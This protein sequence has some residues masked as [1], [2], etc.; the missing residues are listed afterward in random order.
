MRKVGLASIRTLTAG[1][2]A[3]ARALAVLLLAFAFLLP[4]VGHLDLCL[5]DGDQ[6]GFLC[7]QPPA[8]DPV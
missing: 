5:C 1:A 2:V 3:C 4:G 6:H 7:E 8:A